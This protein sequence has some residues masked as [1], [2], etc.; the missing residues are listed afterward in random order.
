MKVKCIVL[1]YRYSPGRHPKFDSPR[2]D[3]G[4][5]RA[6]LPA[7]VQRRPQRSPV[8]GCA[9]RDPGTDGEGQGC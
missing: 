7:G 9:R 8:G 4:G 2:G 5:G 1:T 3:Q 6:E